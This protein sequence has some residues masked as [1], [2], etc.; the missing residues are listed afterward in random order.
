MTA[1]TLTRDTILAELRELKPE[2][3]KR[4]GVSRLGLFG[5]FARN[6]AVAESDIDVVV[7]L[8]EPDLVALVHIKET[9]EEDLGRSVDIIRYR[10]M[11]NN[12]LKGRI[13]NEAIY[14]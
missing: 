9:L 5:S 1:Q 6:E 12:F 4:Y 10:G 13:D 8:A 2:L 11:M 14:V 7:E 3:N